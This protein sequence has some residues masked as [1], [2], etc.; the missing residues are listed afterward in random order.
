MKLT[1]LT[2]P[3]TTAFIASMRPPLIVATAPTPA[4]DAPPQ[5]PVPDADEVARRDVDRYLQSR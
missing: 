1:N 3:A 5:L 2:A 4:P